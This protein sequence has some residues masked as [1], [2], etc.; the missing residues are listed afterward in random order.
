M[1]DV[2]TS[3]VTYGITSQ[4]EIHLE[5]LVAN[6]INFGYCVGWRERERRRKK[7]AGT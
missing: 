1:S 3:R 6:F 7:R 4:W 5:I 2:L